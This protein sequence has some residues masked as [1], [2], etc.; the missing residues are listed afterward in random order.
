MNTPGIPPTASSPELASSSYPQPHQSPHHRSEHARMEPQQIATVPLATTSSSSPLL[1]GSSTLNPVSF[2]Q[3]QPIPRP[4]SPHMQGQSTPRH[5]PQHQ[6]LSPLSGSTFSSSS[7]SPRNNTVTMVHPSPP[8]PHDQYHSKLSD[9]QRKAIAATAAAAIAAAETDIHHSQEHP[10]SVDRERQ[11]HHHNGDHDLFR[12]RPAERIIHGVEDLE[13]STSFSDRPEKGQNTRHDLNDSVRQYVAERPETRQI[14]KATYSGVP[15]F[16]MICK[17]IAVMKRRSDS[18]LNATQILKVAEFDKPQRTRILEREVQ[19]GE[20]EKVQGGYGKYQGTW[21]PFERGVMLCR[22]YNVESLLRPLLEYQLTEQSPPLAPKHIT[23][24][25]FRMK[26]SKDPQT[27]KIRKPKKSS[28]L[29][30]KSV[31]DEH[32]ILGLPTHMFDQNDDDMSTSELEMDEMDEGDVS[33]DET[34]SLLS[35]RSRTPSPLE[36]LHDFSSSEMSDHGV[37]PNHHRHLLSVESSPRVPKRRTVSGD[38]RYMH[39]HGASPFR[40]E[41]RHSHLSPDQFGQKRARSPLSHDNTMQE[42][43][44]RMAQHSLE[45]STPRHLPSASRSPNVSK[46]TE[47]KNVDRTDNQGRYAEVLLQYFIA[48]SV[49][50]PNIL[51]NPPADLDFNLIIDEEGHTPLHWAVAMARTKVVRLLVQHGADVF[52][53]NNQGQ[54]ALMRSVLFTNNFDMKTFPSLLE[55]LQK[56]I[57]TIDNNDQTVFHHV[58]ATAGMRGKVHA[59][60]YYMECL[61]EKLIQHPSELASIINVQDAAGDTALIIAARVGNKKVVRL[62]MDAGADSKIRNKAGRNADDMLGDIEALRLIPSSSPLLAMVSS[63]SLVNPNNPLPSSSPSTSSSSFPSTPA[64]KNPYHPSGYPNQNNSSSLTSTSRGGQY[65]AEDSR[66]SHTVNQHH[67]GGPMSSSRMHSHSH[68]HSSPGPLPHSQRLL[69]N[70]TSTPPLQRHGHSRHHSANPYNSPGHHHSHLSSHHSHPSSPAPSSAPVYGRSN[71]N[72]DGYR[73]TRGYERPSSHQG[74]PEGYSRSR[75]ERERGGQSYSRYGHEQH[76]GGGG[77]GHHYSIG[78]HGGGG[79]QHL[80]GA[81]PASQRMIPAVTELFEQLAQSYESD[82]HEKEQDLIEARKLLHGIQAEVQEGQQSVEEWKAKTAKQAQADERIR[83]LEELVKQEIQVRQ[84]LRMEEAVVKEEVRLKEQEYYRERE[85]SQQ[86][87]LIESLSPEEG[88][89]RCAA[90][91]NEGAELRSRLGQLQERRK[92]QVQELVQLKGGHGKRHHEY[93]RLIA[94]CCNVAVD[95]VDGLLGP[96][97]VAMNAD[98]AE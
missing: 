18:S 87:K 52:R 82:L 53:V 78:G 76:N 57:F 60:R 17:G 89:A 69:S 98:N 19:T 41:L 90:L 73:E 61:V 14:F 7:S 33:M 47:E 85:R 91:E 80:Q 54:T 4:H 83:K 71:E 1:N 84:R 96:L 10:A 46:R 79:S 23:A 29:L 77:G 92:E 51:V 66:M 93:K 58:A 37:S 5:S 21:V 12:A 22:E 59:S 30:P 25:T 36:P 24:T 64:Q 40:H 49:S 26:K 42:T 88:A 65:T 95:E 27:P 70:R 86:R 67:P 15:V 74:D 75:G 9:S 32:R 31:V 35:A 62:L 94:L 97:L 34:T 72:F 11:E 39:Q 2:L 8:T 81:R 68:S 3:P 16:E 63:S 20:H 45:R 38:D 44:H 50:M 6:L 48:D 28:S 43:I 56:T 55:I 13:A